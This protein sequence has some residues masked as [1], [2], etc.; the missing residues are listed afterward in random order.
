MIFTASIACCSNRNH[1]CPGCPSSSPHPSSSTAPWRGAS[2]RPT[3]ASSSA[4]TRRLAAWEVT[5]ASRP[6]ASSFPA[7]APPPPR[8]A[9]LPGVSPAGASSPR[10]AG[11]WAVR[12]ALCGAAAVRGWSRRWL[13]CCWRGRPRSLASSRVG[14]SPCPCARPWLTFAFSPG[15]SCCWRLGFLP[16]SCRHLAVVV[17]VSVRGRHCLVATGFS[18][19]CRRRRRW[20]R[21]D[22]SRAAASSYCSSA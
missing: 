21:Q 14:R 12:A 4:S 9:P 16:S 10:S 13:R 17:M 8:E 11:S 19:Q 18:S 2:P 3:S 5:K 1:R 22:G 7:F 6:F 20:S 15:T